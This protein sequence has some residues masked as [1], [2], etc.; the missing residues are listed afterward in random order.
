MFTFISL[1][2][3]VRRFLR[4]SWTGN[5]VYK[6]FRMLCQEVI[7]Q[8][9]KRIVRVCNLYRERVRS[10]K[11]GLFL[12]VWSV[13]LSSEKTV[14]T[15]WRTCQNKNNHDNNSGNRPKSGEKNPKQIESTTADEQKHKQDC[16]KQSVKTDSKTLQVY[17]EQS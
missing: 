10:I 16:W 15:K 8:H 5:Q 4:S 1:Y 13:S 11:T 7:Y 3:L 17:G 12:F 2:E 14:L 6:Y 9:K